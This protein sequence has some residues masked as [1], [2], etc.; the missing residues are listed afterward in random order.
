MRQTP[1]VTSLKACLVAV[2]VVSVPLDSHG[3]PAA[4]LPQAAEFYVGGLEPAYAD[5]FAIAS[6]GAFCK[7]RFPRECGRQDP[8]RLAGLDNTLRLLE[9]V[10]VFAP[11]PVTH[12]AQS[13]TTAEQ[14]A[15]AL[16][17]LQ[18]S[19]M[20]KALEYE[21]Q[22]L[23]RYAAVNK[24][25][26]GSAAETEDLGTMTAVDFRRFWGFDAGGYAAALRQMNEQADRYMEEIRAL[27]SPERCERTRVLGHDLRLLLNMKLKDY[28]QPGWEKF[29]QRDKLG[30][31]GTFIAAA[32]FVFDNKVHPG[33]LDAVSGQSAPPPR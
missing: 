25:C 12:F 10:T 21:K 7:D 20:G 22:F 30:Q 13:Y 6:L 15:L 19:F 3:A 29:V 11:P 4:A 14:A 8:Q 1:T 17:S 16:V 23:A 28:K 9:A 2:M 27:W 33:A 18:T 5:L 26:R 31:A 24:V 32:T